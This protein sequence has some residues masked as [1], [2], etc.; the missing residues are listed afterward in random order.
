MPR[1]SILLLCLALPLAACDLGP[2][3]ARPA[4]AI[5]AAFRATVESAQAAWPAADWWR[6]F[7]SPELN[8]LIADARANNQNLAAAAARVVQADAEVAIT[9]SP[10][11]PTV[12]GTGNASYSRIG[13]TGSGISG[14]TTGGSGTVSSTS[15]GTGTTTST[16]STTGST[17][18]SGGTS[19][20]SRYTDSRQ[21]SLQ[22]AVS[23]EADFWGKNRATFDSA[24][25]SALFSRFDQENVALTVLTST[26][27]TYFNALGAADQL[28]VAR[29]NLADAQSTLKVFQVRTEVGT[30]TAL[31]I[32]QQEALV[33][34]QAATIPQLESQ[35]QQ[36][37][38]ALAT[39]VGRPP[40]SIT[41][42]ADTLAGLPTPEIGGGLPA[43]LLARRPDVA[44]AEAQIVAQNGN[45]RA[46][47]AAFFPDRAAHHP[48]RH[49][50]PRPLLPARTRQPHL[51][52]GRVRHA[53]DLRQRPQAG[54]PRPGEGTLRRTGGR[55]PPG[56][57]AGVP[58][59]RDL[60][61][62][63]TLRRAT[64]G[65]AAAGG[66][67]GAAG[68]GHLARP[69]G[70]GHGRYHHG[71]EH[72]DNA[73]QRPEHVR[74]GPACAFPGLDKPIQSARRRLD[75]AALDRNHMKL[76]R[77]V[78]VLAILAAAG[79]A[80]WYY[81]HPAP[82]GQQQAQAGRGR[83][84]RPGTTDGDPIPVLATAATTADVP[85]YLDALGTVQA[86]NTVTV[87]AMID[88]PLLQVTFKEGQDV[89]AGD[90]LAQIDPRPYQAALDQA[91]GKKA[92]DDAN[93]A[94][95]RV[96]L[97]RY[98]KLAATAYTSAQTSD[99]QKAT[100][101]QL[102]AQVQQDQAQIDTARTNLSYTTIASPIDGRT[103][104]RQVD[105][106][107]IVHAADTTPLTVITQL[108]P[109]SVVFTL[110]QQTLG[111]V[112]AAMRGGAPE[113]LA[114]P[115]GVANDGET[116][117]D[118]GRVAVLDN[119][120]DQID[121]HDQAE[122]DLPE[123][124]AGAVARRL[125]QRPPADRDGAQR[126]LRAA[127]RGAAGPMGAYVYLVGANST[128]SRKVV[129]IGHEDESVAVVTAGLQAGDRVVTDGASRL[130]D[131]ARVTVQDNTPANV[132]AEPS[133]PRAPGQG[134]Q[135]ASAAP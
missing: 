22:G 23:Y 62:R 130:T 52:R 101:A 64:G 10:L 119:T 75:A 50:K 55:L 19:R 105:S 90:V 79:A 66:G 35:L 48:G 100:V 20:S 80:G 46:A 109:I 67:G 49:R 11:L 89:H 116:V 72:P 43:E 60:P 113:V 125:R 82:S 26:A 53:D 84:P 59:C 88:G 123:P 91:V 133:R 47:R 128:V 93:L 126:G 30:G 81:L 15:T 122:G 111:A 9:G 54:R 78:L 61:G 33:S 74:A 56:D 7:G 107:N 24:K 63:R 57:A 42:K 12:S 40:E 106:G 120:V 4:V 99:T 86:F 38:I 25:A 127:D 65:A 132:T 13:S 115:Q 18:V 131:G 21:Y 102:V 92:Q 85:V 134:R 83:R 117:L 112:A 2:D 76:G 8:Q 28:A 97:V 45:V 69:V 58:G 29:R 68:G 118:R 77:L 71:A 3:Y 95:A 39:L 108:Q 16:T 1:A 129:Q 94:N 98:Q 73:V 104:I 87:K 27:T 32:A 41:I 96:D 110:P 36:Q 5:P 44:S 14:I 34:A 124:L 103:G 135:R 17:V 51:H 31:D 70:G 37:V 6:G 121:R 114:L